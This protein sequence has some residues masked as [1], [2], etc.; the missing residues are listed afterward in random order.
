[1]K[2]GLRFLPVKMKVKMKIK[3]K[4]YQ[5]LL[6]KSKNKLL[7]RSQLRKIIINAIVQKNKNNKN[8][9]VIMIQEIMILIKAITH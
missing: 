3:L 4:N 9:K 5:N 6:I 8:K 2:V 7:R 1:M